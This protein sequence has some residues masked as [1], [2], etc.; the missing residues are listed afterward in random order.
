MAVPFLEPTGY[1]AYGGGPAGGLELLYPGRA[2]LARSLSSNQREE[3]ACLFGGL[4]LY[5][6]P[7][8]GNRCLK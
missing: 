6:S 7:S 3:M 4:V 5:E 2:W 1:L 8:G